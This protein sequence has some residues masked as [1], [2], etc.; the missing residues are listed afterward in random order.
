MRCPHCHGE[1]AL[2]L[3]TPDDKE[4]RARLALIRRAAEEYGIRP[5]VVTSRSRTAAVHSARSVVAYVLRQQGMS[6][7]RIGSLLGRDHSTVMN[8]VATVEK[9]L[10]GNDLYALR[11]RRIAGGMLGKEAA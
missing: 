6:Y 3:E 4:H 8:M 9:R 5:S 10:A 7:P 2:T 11:V 1:L